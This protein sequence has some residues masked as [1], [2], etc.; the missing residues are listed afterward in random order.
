M[1]QDSNP[2]FFPDNIK[3]PFNIGGFNRSFQTVKKDQDRSC[4]I[5]IG[6][7]RPCKINKIIISSV[8]SLG[9]ISS[10]LIFTNQGGP[11]GLHMGDL[12]HLG[13]TKLLFIIIPQKIFSEFRRNSEMNCCEILGYIFLGLMFIM[14]VV[15]VGVMIRVVT[16]RREE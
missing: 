8:Q 10:R 4:V 7:C 6:C 1:H 13:G 2:T 9:G 3:N 16:K 15:G 14:S 11:N 12:A 5:C